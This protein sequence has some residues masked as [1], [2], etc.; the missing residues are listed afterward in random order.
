MR[1]NATL[2][3]RERHDLE[4]ADTNNAHGIAERT[5]ETARSK[6]A[7]A[8]VDDVVARA[9]EEHPLEH[10]VSTDPETISREAKRARRAAVG[11]AESLVE[12]VVRSATEGT[13]LKK[14]FYGIIKAG[15]TKVKERK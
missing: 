11:G 9:L 15:H 2:T 6:R 7:L 4:S 5:T 10:P 14:E 3:T 8:T 1:H 13:K 12:S